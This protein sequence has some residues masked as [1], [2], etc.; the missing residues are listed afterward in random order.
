MECNYIVL[1]KSQPFVKVHARP[2]VCVLDIQ[3]L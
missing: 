2:V 3:T 1:L